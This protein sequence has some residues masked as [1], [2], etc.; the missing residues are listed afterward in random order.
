M[1]NDNATLGKASLWTSIVG[2][3]LPVCLAVLVGIFIEIRD[4]QQTA[5]A[6]YRDQ[7][8]ETKDAESLL[9]TFNGHTKAVSDVAFS[10]DGKR[11][12][13]CSFDDT[14]RIWDSA[15]GKELHV[16]RGHDQHYVEGVAFSAN[17]KWLASAGWD[18]KVVLW[19]AATGHK[20]RTYKV[21]GGGEFAGCVAFSPDSKW[22][23]VAGELVI[24]GDDEAIYILDVATGKVQ[25]TLRGHV[26][27]IFSVKFSGDGKVLATA[28]SQEGEIILWDFATGR[29]LQ[30]LQPKTDR[31]WEVAFSPDFKALVSGGEDGM[32]RLWDVATGKEFR[33]FRGHAKEVMSVA[34]RKG[35]KLLV[36]ASTDGEV[37]LWGFANGKELRAFQGHA[38]AVSRV[39][40][41][42]DGKQ[43]ATASFDQTVKLWDVS[44]LMSA[45]SAFEKKIEPLVP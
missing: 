27:G 39:V 30:T 3:V 6:T 4:H 33:K 8:V 9:S 25:R 28:G 45:K 22:L 41:H 35:G 32:I 38:G 20:V 40:F 15:T 12:A 10:R 5:F 14:V 18:Q 36:S 16:L 23:V 44:G 26:N 24:A 21:A 31:I 19:N 29:K 42:P 2:V 37:K 34:F 1:G 43:L 13:S 17:G 11:I 7:Q